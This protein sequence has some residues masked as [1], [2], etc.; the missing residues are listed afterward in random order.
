MDRPT[1]HERKQD[2]PWFAPKIKQKS[3]KSLKPNYQKPETP[4]GY[5]LVDE[6]FLQEKALKR[7]HRVGY[8]QRQ[9]DTL[10]SGRKNTSEVSPTLDLKTGDQTISE[11]LRMYSRNHK[12]HCGRQFNDWTVEKER[13]LVPRCDHMYERPTRPTQHKCIACQAHLTQYE[14]YCLCYTY[15]C[16]RCKRGYYEQEDTPITS[17]PAYCQHQGKMRSIVETNDEWYAETHGKKLF[18]KDGFTWER[19]DHGTIS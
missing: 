3:D 1:K 17:W 6:Q 8:A 18:G 19:H 11:R 13:Y 14:R 7:H 2:K 9:Q 10:P 15:V 5:N 16:T 12:C 4:S